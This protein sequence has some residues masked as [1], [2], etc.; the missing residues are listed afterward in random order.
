M[1]P[2]DATSRDTFIDCPIL[3][4]YNFIEICILYCLVLF[5]L[6]MPLQE[7][8]FSIVLYLKNIILLKFVYCIVLSYS[9]C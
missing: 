7:I 5:Y 9:T 6:L 3:E 8:P 4:K 1:R 2:A